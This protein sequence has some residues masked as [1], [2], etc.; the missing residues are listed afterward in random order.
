MNLD[1][2]K[3]PMGELPLIIKE[4]IQK[5]IQYF[6][7]LDFQHAYEIH[8][9]KTFS[10]GICRDSKGAILVTCVTDMPQVTPK[11]IDWWFGWHMPETERYKLWH[12]RDHIS[13]KMTV[14]TSIFETDKKKYIH[15]DSYVEEYI[16]KELNNLC[17]SFVEPKDFGFFELNSNQETA[18]CA[19]VKDLNKN[20]TIG[21]LTHLVM[22]TTDGS[23]MQSSF[24]LGMNPKHNNSFLN[25]L[26][27][28]FL[29]IKKLKILLLP[30]K[31]ALDLLIHCAEEM[32]HLT[33]FLPKL[34]NDICLK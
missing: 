30:D 15:I 23:K 6:D 27:K 3:I 12:P 5:E 26:I 8:K 16:G 1:K 7:F 22:K 11:M 9:E 29:N 31:L 20:I 14:D 33:K 21:S 25:F 17:I 13:S 28:P 32:N 18:V 34:Y 19:H 10:T 4:S 2:Y 24:W